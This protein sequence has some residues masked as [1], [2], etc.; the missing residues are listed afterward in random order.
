MGEVGSPRGLWRRARGRAGERDRRLFAAAS[1]L[2]TPLL[3]AVL[4]RLSRAANH[5][6]LWM[7]VAAALSAVREPLGRRAA[8]SGLTALGATSLVVNTVVKSSVRRPRPPID[9]VPVV[10]RL[11]RAPTSWSFPSGHAA[12][13]AAFTTGVAAEWPA[14]GAAIAPVAL[15]VA[16]SRVH[17]GVHYPGDVLAGLAAGAAVAVGVRALH[18]LREAEHPVLPPASQVEPRPGG[19]GVVLVCNSGAGT[20]GELDIDSLGQVLPAAEIVTVAEDEDLDAAMRQVAT[21]AEVL[22]VAGGD[23]SVAAAVEAAIGADIPVLILPGGT[24]NHFAYDLA[25]TSPEAALTALADGTVVE[26]P[27]ARI[28]GRAFVNTSSLGGYPLVVDIREQLEPE[29]GRTLA[30]SIGMLRL[31]RRNEPIE[32]QVDGEPRRLWLLF[33][34][35]GS[36]TPDPLAPMH[37]ARLREQEIDLRC[38]EASP[39]WSRTRAVVRLVWELVRGGRSSSDRRTR[40]EVHSASGPLRAARDGETFDAPSTLVIEHRGE[41]IRVFAPRPGMR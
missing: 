1:E 16:Y 20:G 24:A 17:I 33:A 21:R 18:T 29:V 11:V 6:V 14:A 27:V 30:T 34:G 32:V 35:N 39:T 25:V 5:S 2:D 7:G 36:Y 12:S 40:V 8:L 4:P 13:A 9:E 23:G 15:T 31:L 28:A 19:S 38:V 41:W 3:D 22:G 10:R 26:V 37:R